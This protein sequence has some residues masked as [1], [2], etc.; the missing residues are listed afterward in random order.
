MVEVDPVVARDEHDPSGAGG[1]LSTRY[2]EQVTDEIGAALAEKTGW[3][4]VVYRSTM[5]PGT[6]RW[7]ERFLPPTPSVR[8]PALPTWSSSMPGA[9]G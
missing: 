8:M 6:C 9:I 7:R 3:H 1:G 2:L 4:V 5:V